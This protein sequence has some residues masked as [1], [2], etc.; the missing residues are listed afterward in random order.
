MKK[1]DLPVVELAK[2]KEGWEK[3]KSDPASKMKAFGREFRDKFNLTDREALDYLR[4]DK[5]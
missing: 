3:V 1:E 5:P 2:W 4:G